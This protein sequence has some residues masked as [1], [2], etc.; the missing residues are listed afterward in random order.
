[1]EADAG[2]CAT[3]IA[4][5]ISE[6]MTALSFIALLLGALL[7]VAGAVLLRR[8]DPRG[9]LGPPT[10]TPGPIRRDDAWWPERE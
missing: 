2:S 10:P 6:A 1:M 8:R 9:S 4:R 7:V 5:T 3:G